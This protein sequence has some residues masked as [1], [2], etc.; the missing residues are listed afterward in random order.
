MF[1]DAD[2]SKRLEL[3]LSL[4]IALVSV[5]ALPDFA[6]A[7]PKVKVCKPDICIDKKRYKTKF[8]KFITRS[9]QGISLPAAISVKGGFKLPPLDANDSPT[10]QMLVPADRKISLRCVVTNGKLN[11]YQVVSFDK[12]PGAIT[13]SDNGGAAYDCELQCA[14]EFPDSNGNCDCEVLYNTCVAR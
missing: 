8:R 11:C 14:S 7:G 9:A 12:C 13:V 3:Y 2:W 5:L 6:H 1:S 4:C 10:S